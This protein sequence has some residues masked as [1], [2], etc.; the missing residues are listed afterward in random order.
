MHGQPVLGPAVNAARS[1]FTL[2]RD[3]NRSTG[4]LA[5]NSSV[6][7]CPTAACYGG[8][9]ADSQARQPPTTANSWIRSPPKP[10]RRHL[11]SSSSRLKQTEPRP[12]TG[13]WL[14]VSRASF[15]L[16][17]PCAARERGCW[18]FRLGALGGTPVRPVAALHV[19]VR[20]GVAD[21]RLRLLVETQVPP[22]ARHDVREMAIDRR[23]VPDRDVRIG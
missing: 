14:D 8:P 2:R 18:D 22:R 7:C 16:I 12:E 1:L 20:L 10:P 13:R 9:R 17:D 11:D 15:T 5:M 4:T 21:D 19:E 3:R 6:D 23:K